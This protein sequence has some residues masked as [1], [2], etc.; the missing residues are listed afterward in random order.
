MPHIYYI[1]GLADIKDKLKYDCK[2]LIVTDSKNLI[3]L[4]TKKEKKKFIQSIKETQYINDKKLYEFYKEYMPEMTG[5]VTRVPINTQELKKSLEHIFLDIPSESFEGKSILECLTTTF[6]HVIRKY[7]IEFY[8]THINNDELKFDQTYK[9]NK[10]QEFYFYMMKLNYNL[11]PYWFFFSNTQALLKRLFLKE[12]LFSETKITDK[13]QKLLNRVFNMNG[14][15]LADF[16]YKLTNVTQHIKANR[17]TL[18]RTQFP[19]LPKYK[20]Y[21]EK[22]LR[23]IDNVK[24][25]ISELIA[26]N[27]DSKKQLEEE[28]KKRHGLI[29][30]I[31]AKKI[32]QNLPHLGKFFKE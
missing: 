15:A 30:K 27:R 32:L 4:D 2:E 29:S 22:T 17:N 3:R 18:K 13:K 1:P 24:K 16:D 26:F 9:Y 28:I 12:I 25:E 20:E 14:Q 5:I 7:E 23:E 19:L 11:D 8:I 6:N 21:E 31:T 10:F